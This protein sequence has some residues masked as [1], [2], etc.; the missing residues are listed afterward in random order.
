LAAWLLVTALLIWLYGETVV[1]MVHNWWIDPNYSHGFLVPLVSAGLIWRQRRNLME[2]AAGPNYSGF[3]FLILGLLALVIGQL[4]HELFIQR[5]SLVPV[6]W[7][8]IF[9]AYGWPVGRRVLFAFIYLILMVPLPYVLYDSVAFPLRL[10][11]ASVAGWMIRLTGTPVLVEGNII[12]LPY[13]VMNVVDACSGIRSLVSLL[14]AGTILAY[15]MLPNRW[16]KILIVLLVPPVAVLANALRVVAAG[17]LA[18]NMGSGAFE[19]A[20]HETMGW[21]VFMLAFAMLAGFTWILRRLTTHKG[22]RHA[23]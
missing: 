23:G 21:A 6:L 17:L 7:G 8:L 9:L 1:R 18:K 5:V 19:G 13:I 20:T 4:G 15:L 2:V 14:A 11:A 22:Q 10:V 16:S 3:V 12:H